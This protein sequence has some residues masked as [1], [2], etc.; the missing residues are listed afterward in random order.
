[1]SLLHNSILSFVNPLHIPLPA[2]ICASTQTTTAFWMNALFTSNKYVASGNNGPLSI[3]SSA[4]LIV[5]NG[6]F[7]VP[8]Y[9]GNG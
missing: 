2:V 5:L 7:I 1:M 9:V 3:C 8:P 4:Y 6:W